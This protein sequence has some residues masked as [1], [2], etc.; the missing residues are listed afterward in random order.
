MTRARCGTRSTKLQ[1]PQKR[2][3]TETKSAG[4]E[5]SERS[6]KQDGLQVSVPQCLHA[7]R[8]ARALGGDIRKQEA[9][10]CENKIDGVHVRSF[11]RMVEFVSQAA[12]LQCPIGQTLTE[13][14][15]EVQAQVRGNE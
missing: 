3:K 9:D 2:E 15:P 8:E 6:H 10:F 5:F 14:L 12:D 1:A 11:S 7:L 4:R 13:L